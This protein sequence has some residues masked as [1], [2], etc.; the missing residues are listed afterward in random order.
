MSYHAILTL[1]FGSWMPCK[2]LFV[3]HSACHLWHLLGRNKP[4]R[5]WDLMEVR[6][7]TLEADEGTLGPSCLSLYPGCHKASSFAPTHTLPWY[8]AS[9]WAQEQQAKGPRTETS[10]S[11]NTSFLLINWILWALYNSIRKLTQ[12]TYPERYSFFE[13]LIKMCS[14]PL[15]IRSN[16][17]TLSN[18]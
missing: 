11:E 3:K 15:K 16:F 4:F 7:D 5:K 10:M 9:E 1:G 13:K 17:I 2:G 8:A 18:S 12:L 14:W 6:E